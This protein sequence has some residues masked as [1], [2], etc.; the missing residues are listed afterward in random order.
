MKDSNQYKFRSSNSCTNQSLGI[1]HEI[2]EP[3]DYY[4]SLEV[5][6][7]FLDTSKAFDKN[8]HESLLYKL[9]SVGISGELYE[10]I[11]KFLSGR[12]HRVILSGQASSWRIILVGIPQASIWGPLL[13][14]IYIN[15][16]PNGLKTNAKLFAHDTSLFTV[17]K[18]KNESVNVFNNKLSLILK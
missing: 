16:L 8:W 18:N 9:K 1:T 2:F 15:D 5:R 6:S 14:L 3:F 17:V 7:V 4:L 13:F 12:F 10:I 11:E